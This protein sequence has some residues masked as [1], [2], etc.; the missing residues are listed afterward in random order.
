MLGSLK[1]RDVRVSFRGVLGS[2]W[3]GMLRVSDRDVRVIRVACLGM[4]SNTRGN[5]FCHDD[6]WIQ[7]S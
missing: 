7:L 5:L 6:G 2:L 4:E 1:G 3:W